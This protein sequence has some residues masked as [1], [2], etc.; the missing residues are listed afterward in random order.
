M[1]QKSATLEDLAAIVM[2]LSN[3]QGWGLNADSVAYYVNALRH[4]IKPDAHEAQV[5]RTC[6]NYH[7]DHLLVAALLNQEHQLHL[8]IW[9]DW[10]LFVLR[11]LHQ[12]GLVEMN[13]PAVSVEDLAQESLTAFRSSLTNF[14]YESR[15]KTWAYAVVVKTVK[16]MRRD[17]SAQKRPKHLDSLDQDPYLELAV[18][19]KAIVE[20]EVQEIVLIELVRHILRQAGNDR[21]VILFEYAIVHDLSSRQIAQIMQLHPSRVRALLTQIRAILQHSH[22]LRSWASDLDDDSSSM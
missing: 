8:Q 5:R 2:V 19:D 20:H 12:A 18:P 1:E 3:E 10:S 22:L 4:H 15:L 17:R 7:H 16:R 21:M 6:M 14:R 9:Q 13:D 11:T